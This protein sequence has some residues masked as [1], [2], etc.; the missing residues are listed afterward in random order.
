MFEEKKGGC[1]VDQVLSD[2]FKCKI[3]GVGAGGPSLGSLE[4]HAHLRSKAEAPTCTAC[5]LVPQA[6][7]GPKVEFKNVFKAMQ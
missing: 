3:F 6:L 7:P 4:D 2:C 5:T 1:D